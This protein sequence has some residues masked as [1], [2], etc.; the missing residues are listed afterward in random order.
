MLILNTVG[1]QIRPNKSPG[2]IRPNNSP[3]QIRPNKSD[4]TD[5]PRQTAEQKGM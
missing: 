5:P 3:E 4:R 2:Q 1:L